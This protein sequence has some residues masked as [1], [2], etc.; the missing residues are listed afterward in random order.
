MTEKERTIEGAN[1]QREVEWKRA[2]E[3]WKILEE[4]V[5]ERMEEDCGEDD[6]EGEREGIESNIDSVD[7][8]TLFQLILFANDTN[9]SM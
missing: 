1:K 8:S 2:R 7:T 6:S 4:G 5:A 9:I 3:C